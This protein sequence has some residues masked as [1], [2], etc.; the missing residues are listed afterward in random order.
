MHRTALLKAIRTIGTQV[1]LAKKLGVKPSLINN[2]L[3]R[4]KGVPFEYAIAIECMTQGVV[5]RYE[6]APHVK[7][8]SKYGGD[9]LDRISFLEVEIRL[10]KQKL[11]EKKS[12]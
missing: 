8:Y 4:D 5:S 7:N 1:A 3:N 9:I 6:L 11:L 10:I 12:I 2:W